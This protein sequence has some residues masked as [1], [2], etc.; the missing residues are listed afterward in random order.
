MFRDPLHFVAVGILAFVC[1]DWVNQFAA[2][3]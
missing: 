1:V 2:A 3:F